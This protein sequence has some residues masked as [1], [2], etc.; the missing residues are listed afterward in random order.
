MAPAQRVLL[1][2]GEQQLERRPASPR[3]VQRRATSR[4]TA[5]AALLS[6]PRIAV[7]GVLPAAVD[8]HRLDRRR[9]ASTVSRWAQSRIDALAAARRCARAGCRVGAGPRRRRPPRPRARIAA[10]LALHAS[11]HSRS[12]PNGLAIAA[13]RGER[14][15]EPRRARPRRRG[16]TSWRGRSGSRR[17]PAAR[18]GSRLP[19]SRGDRRPRRPRAGARPRGAL[20]R[21]ADEVAEQRRGALAGAT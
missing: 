8:D 21:G 17:S 5:T 2:G 13:E 14:V 18:T 10:Q 15:V 11:A 1:A 20:E 19:A 4:I 12:C 7:V 9:R 3:R 16:L 6:A